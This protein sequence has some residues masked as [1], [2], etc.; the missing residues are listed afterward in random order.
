[1]ARQLLVIRDSISVTT[2]TENDTICRIS[3]SRISVN[4]PVGLQQVIQVVSNNLLQQT[5]PST[6]P[7]LGNPNT[8]SLEI[9]TKKTKKSPILKKLVASL[10]QLKLSKS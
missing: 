10:T 2:F 9:Q 5:F 8:G 7:V 3:L 1:M 6:H 4:N